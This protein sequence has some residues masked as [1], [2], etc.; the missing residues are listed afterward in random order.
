MIGVDEVGRGP[1]AGPVAVG[2]VWWPQNVQHPMLNILSIFPKGKLR[3]SKKLSARQR[4]KIFHQIETWRDEGKL[5]FAVTL[6]SNRLIDRRGISRAIFL[7]IRR[8]LE[9]TPAR[10]EDSLVVLDGRLRAPEHYHRQ[11]TIV[12][13]DETEPAI[14]LASIAAK[15]IRDR[16]LVNLARKYPQYGLERHKGYGT[17]AHFRAIAAHGLSPIHRRSFLRRLGTAD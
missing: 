1:V 11:Q 13:G 9:V 14:A 15:V 6:V 8:C 16:W 7:G 5:A 17:A 12:R 4:E 10:P 3:D 2:A